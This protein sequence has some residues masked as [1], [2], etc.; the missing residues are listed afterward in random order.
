MTIILLISIDKCQV[1]TVWGGWRRHD[2]SETP[3]SEKFNPLIYFCNFFFV[4]IGIIRST[5]RIGGLQ[6]TWYKCSW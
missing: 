1:I 5:E 4:W 6:R 2:A 3:D